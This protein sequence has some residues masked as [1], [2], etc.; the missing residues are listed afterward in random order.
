MVR[1]LGSERQHLLTSFSR[2]GAQLGGEG[3]IAAFVSGTPKF[4]D[5]SPKPIVWPKPNCV[6]LISIGGVPMDQAMSDLAAP[7]LMAPCW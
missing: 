4:P 2:E 7:D 6:I 1:S 5:E 3:P